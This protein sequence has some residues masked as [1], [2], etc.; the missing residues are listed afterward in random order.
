MSLHEVKSNDPVQLKQTIIYLRAELNKYRMKE[1]DSASTSIQELQKHNSQ[2]Q[3]DF[4][5][6]T[7]TK[8][9]LEKR[10]AIYEKRIRTLERRLR[11][12]EEERRL[13]VK[14]PY[15]SDGTNTI[16]EQW[17]E[18]LED[19]QTTLIKLNRQIILLTQGITLLSSQENQIVELK[20]TLEYKQKLIQTQQELIA[21]LEKYVEQLTSET[22]EI[23]IDYILQQIEILADA[24][25][26]SRQQN[27]Q[28]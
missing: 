16:W 19:F 20:S 8:L 9:K 27:S 22:N 26:K 17:E 25:E 14:I 28:T 18:R 13:L 4:Q 12:L 10:L 11:I 6:L 21:V 24:Y 2:L 15:A 5:N 1:T 7:H 3:E 23:P